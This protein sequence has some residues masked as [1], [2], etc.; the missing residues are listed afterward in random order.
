MKACRYRY[1][2]ILLLLML[3]ALPSFGNTIVEDNDSIDTVTLEYCRSRNA[4]ATNYYNNGHYV[5]ATECWSELLEF[6][7]PPAFTNLGIAYMN[8]LG[9]A[10]NHEKAFTLFFR[11]AD[12]GEPTALLHLGS[13]YMLGIHVA[14]NDSLAFCYYSR[15]AQLGSAAAMNV[16]GRFYK[17]GRFVEADVVAARKWL[18]QSALQDDAEGL[19]LYGVLL[20]K[21]NPDFKDEELGYA[22]NCIYRAAG[23][24]H[25][26][27]LVLIMNAAIRNNDYAQVYRCATA[28]HSQ[29]DNLGTKVLG[30]C[31]RYGYVVR[32]NNTR[33]R[34]LYRQSADGGNEEARKILEKW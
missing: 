18:R 24:G 6:D 27:A 12:M 31:Y 11:A 2:I 13:M 5:S 28:L 32:R 23:K 30:D 19:Y 21:T 16:L 14:Q 25:R 20:A 17:E 8:A 1:G 26:D 3:C 9:V 29:G 10:R 15:S 7:Y 33:A 22:M 4:E 34:E